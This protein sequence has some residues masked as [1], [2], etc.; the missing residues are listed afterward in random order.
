MRGPFN[1]MN[2]FENTINTIFLNI[3]IVFQKSI[4]LAPLSI[5]E[6]LWEW[7]YFPLWGIEGAAK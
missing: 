7:L 3:R 1:C 4:L 2:L 6:G 5:G